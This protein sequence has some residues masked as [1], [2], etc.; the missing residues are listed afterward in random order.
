MTKLLLEI[1]CHIIQ[2]QNKVKESPKWIQTIFSMNNT[3]EVFE[4][5]PNGT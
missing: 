4:N 3:Y 5:R 2:I 1:L